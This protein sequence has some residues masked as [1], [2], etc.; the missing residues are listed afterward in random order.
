MIP[1]LPNSRD[2][3]V[4]QVRQRPVDLLARRATE[5]FDPVPRWRVGMVESLPPPLFLAQLAIVTPSTYQVAEYLPGR[6][7]WMG[8]MP[9]LKI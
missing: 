1:I 6:V 3:P 2:V 7:S 5:G 4:S 8:W 9:L